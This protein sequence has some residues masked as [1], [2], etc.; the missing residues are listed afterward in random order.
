MDILCINYM[1]KYFLILL[2]KK[3]LREEFGFKGVLISDW[4]AVGEMINQI[5]MSLKM[6]DSTDSEV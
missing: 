5:L 6:Y 2:M 1:I 4:G 3:I